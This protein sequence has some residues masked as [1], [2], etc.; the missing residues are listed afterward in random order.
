VFIFSDEKQLGCKLA[1]LYS[2]CGHTV[3]VSL[4]GQ[5]MNP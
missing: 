1:A 5:L 4:L 2:F 3:L